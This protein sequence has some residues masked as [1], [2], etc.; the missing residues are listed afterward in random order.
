MLQYEVAGQYT[1]IFN[2]NAHFF[3]SVALSFLLSFF[4]LFISLFL[5]LPNIKIFSRDLTI[6]SVTLIIRVRF[7]QL[8][9]HQSATQHSVWSSSDE[10]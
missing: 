10:F 9:F 6:K 2:V 3:I 7:I 5:S 8:N 4:H 1:Y